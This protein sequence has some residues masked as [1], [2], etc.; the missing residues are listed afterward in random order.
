MRGKLF[1]ALVCAA[2]VAAV[3]TSV[4]S[5][6]T[7]FECNGVYSNTTLEGPVVVNEG[8]ICVLDHVTVNNGLIVNGGGFAALGVSNSRINGGWTMTGTVIPIDAS[9]N[10]G[11]Y[12]CNNN[13]NGGLSVTNV[14]AFGLPLSFGEL[15][16]GCA[17]GTISGGATFSNNDAAVE[18]DGYRVNGGLNFQGIAGY[19]NELE[20]TAVKGSASCTNVVDDG[21]SAPLVNSYTGPNNGCP[22]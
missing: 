2:S 16:A 5:A 18:L 8:D 12:F 6:D 22:A 15:N 11:A 7:T 3:A 10:F 4:A 17:G 9:F 13:V 21:T 1:A 14:E 19:L 20:A